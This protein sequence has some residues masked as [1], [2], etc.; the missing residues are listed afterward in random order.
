M[1]RFEWW[2]WCGY[3]SVYNPN[4]SRPK[5]M[6]N[7][8]ADSVPVENKDWFDGREG[9]LWFR[10][11]SNGQSC[12]HSTLR[13]D[14]AALFV[15][16]ASVFQTE[17][18]I[19]SFSSRHW[20]K[21]LWTKLQTNSWGVSKVNVTGQMTL[22]VH[23]VGIRSRERVAHFLTVTQY[24]SYF[25][26]QMST[27]YLIQ[28]WLCVLINKSHDALVWI[29]TKDVHF[30]CKNMMIDTHRN[31]DRESINGYEYIDLN[32]ER[33]HRHSDLHSVR[34]RSDYFSI[35]YRMYSNYH[36]TA[37]KKIRSPLLNTVTSWRRIHV[38]QKQGNRLNFLTTCGGW[39]YRG[40]N[41]VCTWVLATNKWHYHS[42]W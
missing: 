33:R 20:V 30:V 27:T 34:C 1:R 14:V 12:G 9:L 6:T 40:Q 38:T 21:S 42:M 36:S 15:T 17:P 31:R 18:H 3:I 16:S 7:L 10:R 2:N 39:F 28:W 24:M 37:R 29:R 8:T 41:S 19:R 32:Q 22:S 11:S 13:A 4:H 35:R 25:G 5:E 26:R 23:V